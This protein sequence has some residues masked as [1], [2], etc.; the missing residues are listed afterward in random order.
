MGFINSQEKLEEE[1]K[2]LQSNASSGSAIRANQLQLKAG[3]TYRMRLIHWLD[4]NSDSER[5]GPFMESYIHSVKDEANRWHTILCPTTFSPKSG[6]DKCPV[7]KTCN[8]LYNSSLQE[9]KNLYYEY[10]RRFNGY[11]IVYVVADPENPDN[12]GHI[13]V[14]RY[15]KKIKEFLHKE[16]FGVS[17]NSESA[18]LDPVGD[19]AFNFGKG[20]DLIINVTT[21]KFE[22]KD[23]GQHR[24]IV[25]GKHFFV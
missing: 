20:Y 12:D 19:E 5:T 18:P 13:K 22:D 9:G 10:R 17:D 4:E 21:E 11:A 14:L 24:E 1:K 23:T 15:G 2:K 3:K 7:C 8:T 16:V 25:T 6:F